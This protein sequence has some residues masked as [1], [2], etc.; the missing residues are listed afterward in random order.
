MSV[1][2]FAKGYDGNPNTKTISDGLCDV[3]Y[4]SKPQIFNKVDW[5]ICLEVGEHI[6][7]QFENILFDNMC[8]HAT[9]GIIM[10]WAFPG[11]P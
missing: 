5:V 8:N 6:P 2:S 4:L 7:K 10:S 3:A 1:C 11:Q 9:E